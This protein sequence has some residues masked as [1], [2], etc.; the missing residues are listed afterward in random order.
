MEDVARTEEKRNANQFVAEILRGI[1]HQK[2]LDKDFKIILK[3]I[4]E[5]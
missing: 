2:V 4:H 1:D 5:I 3:W